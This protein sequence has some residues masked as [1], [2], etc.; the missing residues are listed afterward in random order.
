MRGLLARLQV[1][2]LGI[3]AIMLVSAL[4][5][6]GGWGE[7]FLH[8]W[9]DDPLSAL[10]S[11]VA[12]VGAI[13]ALATRVPGEAR[14][15]TSR[16]SEDTR[17]WMIGPFIGGVSFVGGTSLDRLGLPGGEL[18]IFLALAAA[19]ASFV[20]GHRLPVV[21]R[22]TRRLLVAPFVVMAAV[23][24]H[25]LASVVVEGFAETQNLTAW[26]LAP[27]NLILTL[28]ILAIIGFAGWIFYAMLIFVPRELADPGGSTRSWAVRFGFFYLTLI[29]AMFL[30]G[31]VPVLTP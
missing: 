11:L 15:D 29:A 10:L 19:V 31:A 2:D 9:S 1:E 26:L 17:A 28:S 3:G 20:L 27:E 21:S 8:P 18:L 16:G 12:A 14:F 4:L 25:D 6:T 5:P 7:G 22:P 13:V 30:G 24:F 23:L